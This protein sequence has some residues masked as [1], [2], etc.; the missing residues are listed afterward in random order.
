MS[1]VQFTTLLGAASVVRFGLGLVMSTSPFSFVLLI[2]FFQLVLLA[3][4][5][6][7]VAPHISPLRKFPLAA[8]GPWWKTFLIEPQPN[9]LER[10]MND[11][12]NDGLIRYFGV[13]HGERL[14]ITNPHGTK[15]MMLLQAYNF[16]KLPITQR[17]IGHI[18]GMGLLVVDQDEHKARQL[19]GPL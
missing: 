15:E 17:L 2:A 3:I 18:T 16:S 8:Q 13:F 9:A 12:P 1:Y 19:S 7:G 10:F 11:T 6:I 14:L 4:W 5:L